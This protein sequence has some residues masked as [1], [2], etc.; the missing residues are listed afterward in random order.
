MLAPLR[1]SSN[2]FNISHFFSVDIYSLLFTLRS[3]WSFVWWVSF[4]WNLDI[5]DIV[6]CGTAVFVCVSAT[7][8]AVEGEGTAL[9]LP[10]WGKC[11]YSPL[12]FC[13]HLRLSASHYSLLLCRGL[14]CCFP[15]SSLLVPSLAESRVS[16]SFLFF[17]WPPLT[18]CCRE[19]TSLLTVGQWWS[20]N[21][22]LGFLWY[23]PSS[24]REKHLITARWT[25]KSC[26]HTRPSP[27]TSLWG[28]CGN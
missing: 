17:I 16:T 18:A 5:L 14:A 13:W 28:D 1:P 24:E 15:T 19:V 3:Y 26:L 7:T 23:H 25:W 27:N 22:P 10:D 6:L 2:N 21:S 8:L 12:D 11:S 4:Y 9:L 20:L